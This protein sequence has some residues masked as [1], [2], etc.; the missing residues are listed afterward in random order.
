MVGDWGELRM[1]TLFTPRRWARFV[2]ASNLAIALVISSSACSSSTHKSAA[3]GG[4]AESSVTDSDQ[5]DGD[6]G[7]DSSD[8]KKAD[9]VPQ[10]LAIEELGDGKSSAPP[11]EPQASQS[12]PAAPEPAV[13]SG[14]SAEPAVPSAAAGNEGFNGNF[15]E[16][17]LTDIKY[18]S[19]KAGGTVVV[20]TSAPATYHT[21][22]V[23]A[24]SQVIIEIANAQL[25]EKLKRPYIT[26]DFGQS[27]ASINAY[28]DKGSSTVR[29]V[30][31]FKSPM[32]ADVRQEG[33]NLMLSAADSISE[34]DDNP[35]L[36]AAPTVA[37]ANKAM[38]IE[39][40]MEGDA[41]PA[42]GASVSAD[43]KDPRI[44][45]MT[46]VDPKNYE[47]VRFYGKPISIEVRDTPVRDVINLIAEQSGANIVLGG[48]VDGK[49]S[50]K[51]RQIPWDQALLTVMKA[52]NLGYVRQGSILRVAPYESLQK[53][54]ESARKVLDAQKAA[55]PLRVKVIPVGY[56]KVADLSKYVEP[57]L[58]PVRGR[59]VGDTRTN[60]LVV[61]DTMEV[62]ERIANLVKALDLPPLQVL[63]EGKVVEARQT[64]ERYF[65]IRWGFKG[66]DFD[67]G[68]KTTNQS[69][70]IN[71]PVP[72][73]PGNA[74]VYNFRIGQFD[75]FGDINA[76]LG[77]AETD[78]QIHV[79]SSPRVVALNN[80]KAT[81]VQ[82]TNI[83]T[84]TSNQSGGVTTTTVTYTPVEMRLEVTP[85][86]TSENDVIMNIGIKR[87][88]P[89]RRASNGAQPDINH[90]E[91]NT[92]VL[93]RNGQT[94]VI[95]GVYQ[96]DKD[97]NEQGV[98]WLR[99]LPVVGWLFKYKANTSEKTELLVF[100]TPR[101][102]NS[103]VSTPKENSL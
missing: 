19:K 14:K 96:S 18:V 32:H 21:R 99:N 57:F 71:M 24:Q 41:P 61:T 25:P 66:Q 101:I 47:S 65:G 100:L 75:I 46:S 55:E 42:H 45:P 90:R 58:T 69:L 16:V 38:N 36:G 44:L 98:P 83:P 35:T 63:I 88:F 77:L 51:L 2:F 43:D 84:P 95:G 23:P 52:R 97:D 56:A 1:T 15:S 72:G 80:E 22:E 87:D 103:E 93:V 91:A 4:D 30:V 50:L 10:D 39:A 53:E 54:T 49:I 59:V 17:S 73:V 26:K 8:A 67:V 81:I 9:A 34:I 33:R 76:T 60:S 20:E 31:Q 27:I 82:G 74:G 79:V 94:A 11:S 6:F 102:L 28:Q 78:D 48:E 40:E 13:A 37:A 5:T 12:A 86:V 3:D 62:L 89:G 85:Q 64:F 92:K 29:V 7:L 68:G 70:D